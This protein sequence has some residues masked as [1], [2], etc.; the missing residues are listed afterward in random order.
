MHVTADA[1]ILVVDDFPEEV[2]PEARKD[3]ARAL[4]ES[5]GGLCHGVLFFAGRIELA[6]PDDL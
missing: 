4:E 3:M 5:S 6:D 2:T 1:Y